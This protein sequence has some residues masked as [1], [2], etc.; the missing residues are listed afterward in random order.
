MFEP[1]S[2]YYDLPVATHVAEDGREIAY[3]RRRV[4][5]RAEDMTVLV[6][7]TFV[8]GDRLDL[9][10]ARLLGDPEQ[11]W[12]ICDANDAMDPAE[13]TA[14]PGGVIRVAAPQLPG[15]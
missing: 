9:I 11:F 12:R 13:L 4:L 1:T 5:P 10:A 6:E 14:E 8:E 15:R 3:K 2:R 7:V